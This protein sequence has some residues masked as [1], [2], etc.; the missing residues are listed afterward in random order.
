MELFR[1]KMNLLS[2]EGVY[3][4]QSFFKCCIR[5]NSGSPNNI[6][7]KHFDNMASTADY[8]KFEIVP[9]AIV[10][11]RYAVVGISEYTFVINMLLVH[12][13]ILIGIIRNKEV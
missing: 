3:T 1:R 11:N 2:P 5:K 9:M 4:V 7:I 10:C 6:V 12:M 13:L 8:F